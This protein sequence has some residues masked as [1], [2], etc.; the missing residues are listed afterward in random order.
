MSVSVKPCFQLH[1]L[2]GVQGQAALDQVRG[3]H[4]S[5]IALPALDKEQLREIDE[6]NSSPR[7]SREGTSV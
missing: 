6:A 2:P 4:V 7:V 1:I 5:G 3:L